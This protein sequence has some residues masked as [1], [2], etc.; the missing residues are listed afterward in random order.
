MIQ[1]QTQAPRERERE[2]TKKHEGDRAKTRGQTHIKLTYNYSYK[3]FNCGRNRG[4]SHSAGPA[5]YS[6]QSEE[7]KKS[8]LP[9][10]RL[11]LGYG[12]VREAKRS[13]R[14]KSRKYML[15]EEYI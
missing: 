13:G 3:C 9:M 8:I 1:K 12:N 2:I 5:T 14:V 4:T 6:P 11:Y 15:G 10:V 7:R